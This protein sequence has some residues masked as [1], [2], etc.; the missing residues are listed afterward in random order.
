MMTAP[1]SASCRSKLLRV[2]IENRTADFQSIPDTCSARDREYQ[3][4]AKI[5]ILP[6]AGILVKNRHKSGRARS[7]SFGDPTECR[8]NPRGSMCWISSLIT[9]V[10]PDAFQPS[11]TM[12]IGTRCSHSAR[13][14]TPISTWRGF[15]SFS[16]VLSSIFFDRSH[17]SNIASPG[18]K[19]GMY[20]RRL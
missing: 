13:V 8:E 5:A 6:F 14:R 19:K 10:I 17:F 2:S 9:I 18:Y 3:L 15:I 4:R 1:S 7:S 20:W 12:M 11:T 16:N